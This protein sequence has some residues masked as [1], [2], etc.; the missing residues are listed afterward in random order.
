MDLHIIKPRLRNA[1][2]KSITG[3]GL[4]L[5]V[6][7]CK[8]NEGTEEGPLAETPEDLTSL[9]NPFIGTAP[10][11]DPEWI[12]YTPPENWRV[13]AGLVYPGSALPNAMVQLSPVTEYGTGAGYEY[14]DTEILGFA[15]TNKGHWNL[16]TIPVL[17][18]SG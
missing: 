8:T 2:R 18:E 9:V 15:N 10:L 13:W 12:G 16:V 4:L 6:T 17:H 11:T 5:I 1:F 14:E 3:L 7:S